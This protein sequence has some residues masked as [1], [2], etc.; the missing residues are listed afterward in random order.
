MLIVRF[1]DSTNMYIL[2]DFSQ[3]GHVVTLNGA[4]IPADETSGFYISREG[5]S[6]NWDY[7]NFKTIYRVI[8]EDT[9]QYS[10]DGSVYNPPMENVTIELIWNDSDNAYGVRPDVVI[11]PITI[12][13]TTTKYNLRASKG[14]KY[15]LGDYPEGSTISIAPR[16][17]AHYV[18]ASE[19]ATVTYTFDGVVPQPRELSVDALAL[20]LIKNYLNPGTVESVIDI[21]AS[22]CERNMMNFNEVPEAAQAEVTNMIMTDGF[23]V[24]ED[25]TTSLAP[26]SK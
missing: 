10:D 22:Y 12:N 7:T 4:N 2:S 3:E 17:V 21:Y 24:N 16:S 6:D 20:D 1:A 26:L 8:D 5:H 15:N 25:G 23:V 13:G 11:V 19:R 9:V 14:W 18:A